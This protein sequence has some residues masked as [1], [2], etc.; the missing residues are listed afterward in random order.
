MSWVELSEIDALISNAK[1][2]N[3]Q[4]FSGVEHFYTSL[5]NSLGS[6]L[7]SRYKPAELNIC[8]VWHCFHQTHDESGLGW[9]TASSV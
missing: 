8:M 5:H 3:S 9:A 4:T 6:Y 2:T 7:H 1:K